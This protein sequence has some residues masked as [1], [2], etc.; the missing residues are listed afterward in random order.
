MKSSFRSTN[1]LNPWLAV[2]YSLVFPGLGQL[3][4]AFWVKGISLMLIT[5]F[6]LSYATWFI[7]G[8]NGQTL[9]GFWTIACIL[10]V[11]SFSILDAYRGTQPGYATRISVPQGKAD[12]WYAVFLSQLL[13]G[14]GH[15]YLQQA[16]AGGIFL[17]TGILT[18]WLANSVPQLVPIPP[19][20]WALSCYHVYV[21]FPHRT[22][23]NSDAIALLAVGLLVLRLSLAS[24]PGW[25]RQTV[26]QCIVPSDSMTPTLQVDDRLFVR[27]DRAYRPNSGDIIVFTPPDKA[28]QDRSQKAEDPL[29]NPLLY[30]KRVIGLPG[31]QVAVKEGQIYINERPLAEPYT[32]V[33]PTYD[34]GP[35]T[36]PAN[37][38]FVL[39][40]NRPNSYDSHVWG[41]VPDANILGVAYKI[42]WPSERVQPLE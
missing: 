3:Y 21:S 15:L 13:P 34:W 33:T 28:L 27:R 22:K 25:I 12:P 35:E 38:Y 24:T 26:E 14:L 9:W 7:F 10:V 17:I 8:A 40:D 6:M 39:G 2:N 19:L 37:N 11:Y 23:R 1:R 42:Y 31:Q 16:L 29:E 4:S 18:A 41:Y 32:Q 36:V 20:I 5:V 30:V